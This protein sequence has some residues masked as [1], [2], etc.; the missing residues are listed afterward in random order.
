[1]AWR[2]EPGGYL[3]HILNA[4]VYDIAVRAQQPLEDQIGA[5]IVLQVVAPQ[6][7]QGSHAN[8]VLH[9]RLCIVT[10]VQPLHRPDMYAT[11]GLTKPL[12][13]AWH[14][15]RPQRSCYHCK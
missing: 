8:T 12:P 7:C 6:A 3:R 13:R 14:A 9:A 1:M 4:R 5:A 2:L 10:A 15:A 11:W